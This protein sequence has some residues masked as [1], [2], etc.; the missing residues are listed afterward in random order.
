MR[1]PPPLHHT[2]QQ[3]RHDG[4]GQEDGVESPVGSP[5]G[6]QEWGFLG[7]STGM[8]GNPL[9]TRHDP[10]AGKSTPRQRGDAGYVGLR[11]M[12]ACAHGT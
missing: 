9:P 3:T 6:A 10:G 5:P 1:S 7:R 4:P 2:L 11:A 8:S 12:D